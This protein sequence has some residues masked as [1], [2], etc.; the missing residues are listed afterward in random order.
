MTHGHELRGGLLEGRGAPGRVGAKGENWYKCDNIISKIYKILKYIL[1]L[2]N[3]FALD[4]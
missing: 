4:F 1:K 2:S 3:G